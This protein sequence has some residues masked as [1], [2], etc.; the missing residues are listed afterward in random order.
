MR[1]CRLFAASDADADTGIARVVTGVFALP[2]R[3]R[4]LAQLCVAFVERSPEP[5]HFV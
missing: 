4:L 3:A 1:K 2:F 5:L